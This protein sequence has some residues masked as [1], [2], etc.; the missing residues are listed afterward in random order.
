MHF[1]ILLPSYILLQKDQQLLHRQMYSSC[2][3]TI[4]TRAEQ[5]CCCQVTPQQHE[6]NPSRCK[7][8]V[9]EWIPRMWSEGCSNNTARKA[10]FSKEEVA[11][12]GWVSKVSC[13]C[14]A[15]ESLILKEKLQ[16]QQHVCTC[17]AWPCHFC[18][19]ILG[20][21]YKHSCTAAKYILWSHTPHLKGYFYDCPKGERFSSK[22]AKRKAIP[23][24]DC[25]WFKY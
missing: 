8:L 4:R 5:D 2:L 1:H 20:V 10:R 18:L 7:T 9:H 6:G 25:T 22:Q 14:T 13:V 16:Q 15:G 21:D 19:E 12:K 23:C 11:W 17:A 3:A 24:K